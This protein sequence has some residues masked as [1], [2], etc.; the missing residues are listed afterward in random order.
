[1]DTTGPVQPSAERPRSFHQPQQDKIRPHVADS[2]WR[3]Q[4]F[5]VDPL[6]PGQ[7]DGSQVPVV[8]RS[9]NSKALNF[10]VRVDKIGL[11]LRL[12]SP[13]RG[14]ACADDTRQR[15]ELTSSD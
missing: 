14:L 7:F 11:C 4:H 15:V 2:L 8:W 9:F 13:A 1:M 10:S 3:R 12:P 6:Y 5:F